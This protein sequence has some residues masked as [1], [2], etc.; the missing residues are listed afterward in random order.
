[1][2]ITEN[3]V[4][5]VW[6]LLLRVSWNVWK[7]IVHVFVAMFA[8]EWI[9]LLRSWTAADESL[10]QLLM[11]MKIEWV[12]WIN[13][14]WLRFWFVGDLTMWE[15]QLY[16]WLTHFH[17]MVRKRCSDD[18][19]NSV[20]ELVWSRGCMNFNDKDRFR[21]NWSYFWS[22]LVHSGSHWL[23][24]GSHLVSFQVISGH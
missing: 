12:S 13:C 20:I 18:F 10:K 24:S 5:S 14:R 15:M 8:L 1:M 16:W 11:Q 2:F 17:F 6:N 21:C 4:I 7:L 19:M 22:H 3:M 23:H 9:I